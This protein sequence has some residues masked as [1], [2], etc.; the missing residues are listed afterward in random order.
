MPWSQAA[1]YCA[2]LAL[3]GQAWRVPSLNELATLV[4]EANVSPAVAPPFTGVTAG[5]VKTPSCGSQTWFLASEA[6]SGNAAQFWGIN[7]CDGYTGYNTATCTS[8]GTPCTA[9]WN[10]FTEG[11]VR[12]V[13]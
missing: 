9:P 1:A 13:R 10:Y 2:G 8:A 5:T 3:N 12:C 6:W 4:N 7:F 11:F